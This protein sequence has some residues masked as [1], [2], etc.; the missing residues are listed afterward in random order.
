MIAHYQ[1]SQELQ[2]N[3]IEAEVILANA[4]YAQGTLPP[5]KQLHYATL[6]YEL[7]SKR[8]QV[9]DFKVAIE[10]YRQSITMQPTLAEAHYHLG[11]AFQKLGSLDDAIAHYQSAQALQPDCL[12]AKVSLAN[13]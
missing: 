7:G 4:R 5:D 3:S 11:I 13:R 1:K 12:E 8:K 6:N 9:G 2:P 10:Y